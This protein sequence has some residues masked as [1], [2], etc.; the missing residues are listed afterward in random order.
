METE[1]RNFLVGTLHKDKPTPYDI[2]KS[3][4]CYFVFEKEVEI[5]A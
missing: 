3:K 4:N 1:K 2:W 5:L